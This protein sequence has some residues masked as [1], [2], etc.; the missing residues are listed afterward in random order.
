MSAK[1]GPIAFEESSEQVFLGRDYSRHSTH[2]E[3]TL[4]DIDAEVKRIVMEQFARAR[5]ILEANRERVETLTEALLERETID[6]EE[7]QIVMA[8]GDLPEPEIKVDHTTGD[9]GPAS[10]PAP[11]DVPDEPGPD[12]PP[13]TPRTDP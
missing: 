9:D 1:L 12:L 8:G 13:G 11:Q 7:F 2:S 3:Q 5:E 6:A 10:T 4:Q